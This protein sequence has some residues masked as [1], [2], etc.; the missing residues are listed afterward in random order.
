[1]ALGTL[2]AG[3]GN[4]AA[5]LEYSRAAYETASRIQHKQWMVGGLMDLGILHLELFNF[6]ESKEYLSKALQ[7]AV[8]TASVFWTNMATAHLAQCQIQLGEIEQAREILSGKVSSFDE[9]QSIAK[10]SCWFASASV[11]LGLG[12]YDSA[13]KKADDLIRTAANLEPGR[14]I[15]QLWLV[16]AK[17]LSCLDRLTE[18][19]STLTEALNDGRIEGLSAFRWRLAAELARV[20]LRTGRTDLADLLYTEARSIVDTL[21][22]S[23]PDESLKRNYV[24]SARRLILG[25]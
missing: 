12:N 2:F 16:R 11:D 8:E 18:A 21:A 24:D 5:A 7:L 17:A 1:M 20:Y 22:E 9:D 4:F 19:E 13:L 10:R 14:T 23:I 15:P 6:Q 3:V 25:G